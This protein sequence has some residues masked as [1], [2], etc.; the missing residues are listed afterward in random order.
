MGFY[1]RHVLPRLIDLA[2]RS[3]EP[4]AERR[5][6]I[7]LAGGRVIEIGFGSGLNVSFYGRDV[8]R[9]VAVDPSIELWRLGQRRVTRAPVRVEFTQASAERLPFE[10]ATFDTAVMTWT[11][12]SISDAGAA[13]REVRRVL[14]ATG[15]LL[16][17]EHGRASDAGVRVW[18]DRLTPG[19]RRLAGGCHLNR[20]IDRLLTH[21][22]F[23]VE[24][25]ERGYGAGPRPFSYLYRGIARPG[26]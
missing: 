14:T 10:S 3:A 23:R 6:L 22:G 2:M 11:L 24:Q 12:C 15:R 26:P 20:E 16:F 4:A 19:W 13:L 5:K 17:V 9:L 25:I 1:A 18:Q 21:G 7:P 8:V